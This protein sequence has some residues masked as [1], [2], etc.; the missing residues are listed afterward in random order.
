MSFQVTIDTKDVDRYVAVL[1]AAPPAF[2]RELDKTVGEIVTTTAAEVRRFTPVRTGALQ[3]SI[4]GQRVGAFGGVVVSDAVTDSR[5]PPVQPL[6]PLVEYP[7]QEHII[8]PRK[9]GGVLSWVSKGGE[10]RF[11]KWV[12]HP[13]TKGAFMF[14]RGLDAA[15]GKLPAILDRLNNR[16]AAVLGGRR[17]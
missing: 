15:Q 8:A 7:T 5:W 14:K 3:K 4:V 11:A 9:P 17:R 16:L 2:A 12:I 1:Q 6:A 13:G 10:R